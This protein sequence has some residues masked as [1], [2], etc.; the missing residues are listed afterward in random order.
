MRWCARWECG[1]RGTV[2]LP[3]TLGALWVCDRHAQIFGVG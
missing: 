1:N 3:Y 2:L